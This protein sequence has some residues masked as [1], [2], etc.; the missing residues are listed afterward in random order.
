MEREIRLTEGTQTLLNAIIDLERLS[1]SVYCLIR[2][3]L[4]QDDSPTDETG[5]DL[6]EATSRLRGVIQDYLTDRLNYRLTL[7]E[8]TTSTQV[9]L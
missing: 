8:T 9:S 4:S 6:L 3:E 1:N 5:S 2:Q 7:T